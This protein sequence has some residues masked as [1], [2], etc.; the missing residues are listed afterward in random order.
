MNL[1]PFTLYLTY[2]A[3][4]LNR[5]CK[6]LL[7]YDDTADGETFYRYMRSGLLNRKVFPFIAYDTEGKMMCTFVI[8]ITQAITQK[9][10]KLFIQ[11]VWIDAHYPKFWRK[12][13]K[14]LEEACRTFGIKKMVAYT[15]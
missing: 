12:G 3:D 2:E 14:I 10:R 15:R 8:N 7:E 1:K 5:I 6:K 9:E 13:M 4:D 11:G